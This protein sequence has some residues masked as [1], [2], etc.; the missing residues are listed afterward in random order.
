[1]PNLTDYPSIANADRFSAFNGSAQQRSVRSLLLE[2]DGYLEDGFYRFGD[3]NYLS[4]LSSNEMTDLQNPARTDA[5]FHKSSREF[6]FRLSARWILPNPF[7]TPPPS[8]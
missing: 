1:M 5:S 8:R 7:T 6:A 2:P 4:E 3:D